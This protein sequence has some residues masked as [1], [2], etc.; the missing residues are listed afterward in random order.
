MG[1]AGVVQRAHGWW[2]MGLSVLVSVIFVVSGGGMMS[3]LG[4]E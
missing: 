3:T 2:A 4:A 1:V